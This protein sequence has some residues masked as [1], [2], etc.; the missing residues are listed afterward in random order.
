MNARPL[1]LELVTEELPPK[2]L[3]ALGEAFADGIEKTLQAQ[4]LLAEGCVR[5]AYAS[6]RRLAVHLSAVLDQAADQPFAE[7]LMPAAIG[8]DASGAATPALQKKLH[9]KG[10]DHLAVSQLTRRHDGK[11]DVLYAEGTAPGARLADGLQQALDHAVT[12]LPIPKVMQY[13]LADGRTSVKFVRPAHHLLAL[14]GDAVVPVRT[15]GLKADRITRG[16]RFLCQDPITIATA[17]EWAQRLGHEGRVIPSFEQRRAKIAQQLADTS[18][19]L[20]ATIG[21]SPEAEALLDE[22]TA[23]VEWPTV[24]VGAFEKEFLSVPPECLILTMRLNQKYFPLFDPETGALTHRFLIVSNMQ[25]QDPTFIIQGNQRVVR[26]R[27]ADA[28]FFYQTDLKTPLVE[29]VAELANSVYHNKLGSQL[30]RTERVR[31]LAHWLAPLLGGDAP[32][33]ARAAMLAHADLGTQMVGEFPEL[34][35]IMG[36]YYAAHDGEPADVVRALR[37]QYRIRLDAPVSAETLTATT[38]FMAERAETLIGIWGIGLAPTGERDPYG[39]RRAALGLISAYEQLTAGGWLRANQD[40]PARLAAL[41]EQ[42]AENFAPGTLADGT[43]EAVLNFVYERYRNLLAAS[44]ERAAIDAVLA[45]RPPLH[46]VAARVQACAD[47]V[48]LPQA[49]ALAAANKR[50]SN[51][52]KKAEGTLPAIDDSL[53]C[54]PAERQLADT[55]ARLAPQARHELDAGNF[56]ASLAVLAQAR[57]A[58]DQFFTEVMVMADDPQVRANRLALLQ[59]LHGLMNQ[60][61]DLSRLAQ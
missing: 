22:V 4:H 2:A 61:A 58:V 37:D 31:K 34:Q 21:Q 12:H 20:G 48:A 16:H 27:L 30:Q 23:L 13:Q 35:G 59:N 49:E 25:P 42:A 36:A 45:L 43:V 32:A 53:L 3:K 9:A 29:R 41:L 46:Q 47:F 55:I 60:V 17:D 33:A 38:L 39:L 57:D 11:Q 10:L 15:L 56:T 8:L 54:E 6:P 50:V 40:S 14:W 1:I 52:L 26:P 19:A 28:Q 51:L 24:Y 5:T 18:A 44:H 7:K